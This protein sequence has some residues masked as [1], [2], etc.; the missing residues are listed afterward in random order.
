MLG[1]LSAPLCCHTQQGCEGCGAAER[2]RIQP[3]SFSTRFAACGPSAL[4]WPLGVSC[5]KTG[6]FLPLPKAIPAWDELHCVLCSLLHITQSQERWVAALALAAVPLVPILCPLR[7]CKHP[8]RQQCWLRDHQISWGGV[9]LG[10][11][12]GLPNPVCC[13][14]G[15]T[16]WWFFPIAFPS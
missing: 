6:A 4:C 16:P 1:L 2:F 10:Q 12:H 11:V 9:S 15:K 8:A 14:G 7:C 13:G 3:V 5:W